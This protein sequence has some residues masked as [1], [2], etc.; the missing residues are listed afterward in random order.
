MIFPFLKK[1]KTLCCSQCSFLWLTPY[2]TSP[3]FRHLIKRA[4]F[5]LWCQ[6]LTFSLTSVCPLI[7]SRWVLPCLDHG[8][9]S[10]IHGRSYTP[11]AKDFQGFLP[12]SLGSFFLT[13]TTFNYWRSFIL[14]PLLFFQASSQD[15][16]NK[17][18][19]FTSHLQAKD[20]QTDG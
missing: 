16:I 10:P 14:N 18:C 7:I 1:K 20:S 3:F 15:Q 9:L 11:R 12:P 4:S 19:G 8:V 17:I 2:L 13:T 6:T 5:L